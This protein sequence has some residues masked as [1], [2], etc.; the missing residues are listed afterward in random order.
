MVSLQ[1]CFIWYRALISD[2]SSAVRQLIEDLYDEIKRQSPEVVEVSHIA[3]VP[4]MPLTPARIHDTASNRST[5]LCWT[6]SS[7]ERHELLACVSWRALSLVANE[8]LAFLKGPGL[9]WFLHEPFDD[10]QSYARRARTPTSTRS[11]CCSSCSAPS[12][13]PAETF[14]LN[15]DRRSRSW[16]QDPETFSAVTPCC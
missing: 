12:T 2:R 15:Q 6:R 9:A 14:F 1:H 16:R 8:E 5:S 7:Q 11:L 4:C 10:L 3:V 13:A